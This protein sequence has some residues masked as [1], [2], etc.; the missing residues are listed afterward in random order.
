MT[1]NLR[2]LGKLAVVASVM[3]G[4][5]WALIPRHIIDDSPLA[6]DLAT[7]ALEFDKGD[8][9]VAVEM[10]WRKQ[11]PVGPAAKWLRNRLSATRVSFG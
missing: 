11:R 8:H 5:G 1:N 4:F 9:P 10:V 6:G 2:M 3:F 7:P